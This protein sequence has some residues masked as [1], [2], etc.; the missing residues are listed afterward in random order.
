M[1]KSEWIPNLNIY[2]NEIHGPRSEPVLAALINGSTRN[3]YTA[4]SA[5][6]SVRVGAIFFGFYRCGLT[7]RTVPPGPTTDRLLCVD[8][9][10]PHT[11]CW[12]RIEMIHWIATL[13]ILLEPCQQSIINSVASKEIFPRSTSKYNNS[14]IF[15]ND[16][17][18]WGL[19]SNVSIL[20]EI[21]EGNIYSKTIV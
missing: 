8:P 11:I 9:W 5:N 18:F 13:K 3:P 21:I 6:R 16:Y 19:L 7:H 15:T 2:R 12:S 17:G 14:Q 10:V 20:T 4:W 1:I